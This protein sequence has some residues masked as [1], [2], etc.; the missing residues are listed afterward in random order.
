[1][2]INIL[3]MK[4]EPVEKVLGMEVAN[5]TVLKII[6]IKICLMLTTVKISQQVQA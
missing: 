6:L 4:Q 2:E 3:V 1:M 5:I